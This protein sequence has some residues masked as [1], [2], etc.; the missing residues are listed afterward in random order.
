MSFNLVI[1]KS[2]SEKESHFVKKKKKEKSSFTDKRMIL[3]CF[4]FQLQKQRYS[5]PLERN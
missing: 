5:L 4:A 3:S 1:L 2:F